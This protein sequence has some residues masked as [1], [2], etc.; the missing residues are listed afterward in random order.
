MKNFWLSLILVASCAAP[1]REDPQ[2]QLSRETAVPGPDDPQ[3]QLWRGGTSRVEHREPLGQF[4]RAGQTCELRLDAGNVWREHDS[5]RDGCFTK[6]FTRFLRLAPRADHG[7]GDS[8]TAKARE[9]VSETEVELAQ[10]KFWDEMPPRK[11]P[12]Y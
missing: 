8:L 2:A 6:A 9:T 7:W 4:V 11:G 1:G 10:K 12:R 5:R 3:A